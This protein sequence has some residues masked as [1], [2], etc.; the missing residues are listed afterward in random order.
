[1][2]GRS[3]VEY[4]FDILC[5]YDIDNFGYSIGID[6]PEGAD[7]VTL[8]RVFLFDTKAY[9]AGTDYKVLVVKSKLN[10]EAAKFAA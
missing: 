5:N 6:F 2:T 1:M 9:D 10:P 7:D 8:D 3:G 4:T